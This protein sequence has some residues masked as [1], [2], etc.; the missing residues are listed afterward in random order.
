M[1]SPVWSYYIKEANYR[2]K[3]K[4]PIKTQCHSLLKRTK[5]NTKSLWDHLLHVHGMTKE[6]IERFPL[7]ETKITEY[8]S[9]KKINDIE[10]LDSYISCLVA[11][12]MIP[13]NRIV[14][15]HTIKKL[16]KHKFV[17]YE[18]T[19]YTIRNIITNHSILV[20]SL[21][22]ADIKRR[23]ANTNAKINI[24]F[25][26]WTGRSSRQYITINAH[27]DDIVF[28]LGNVN[29]VMSILYQYVGLERICES[30]TADYLFSI[31]KNNVNK[32]DLS[33]ENVISITG[34]GSS[35]NKK[36][37]KV[38]KIPIQLCLNHGIHLGSIFFTLRELTI[39]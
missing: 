36:I 12:D 1:V 35:V 28:C 7:K 20:R 3:C 34:D 31:I 37:A 24:S 25:D 4:N 39:S 30:P 23:L 21:I 27:F 16:L 8:I 15:S 14:K 29:I 38:S 11:V 33:L 22:A 6:D 10:T 2:A 5:G 13:I 9:P 32:F 18:L 26:E 17:G 19:N